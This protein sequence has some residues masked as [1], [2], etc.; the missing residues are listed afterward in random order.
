MSMI[1]AED[2]AMIVLSVMDT[3]KSLIE[4]PAMLARSVMNTDKSSYTIKDWTTRGL[5]CL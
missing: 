2:P 1:E 4:D 3:D 5:V